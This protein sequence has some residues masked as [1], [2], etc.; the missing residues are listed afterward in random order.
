[1]TTPIDWDTLH[2]QEQEW[3]GL[4][5]VG[6]SAIVRKAMH[7][8]I[9][10][11]RMRLFKSNK[12]S[13]IKRYIYDD[14]RQIRTDA[15]DRGKAIEKLIYGTET[16]PGA[17][18]IRQKVLAAG[19]PCSITQPDDVSFDP[20]DA[21]LMFDNSN[22]YLPRILRVVP[23]A[24]SKDA[25]FE[26][27]HCYRDRAKEN[28]KMAM[29]QIRYGQYAINRMQ[30]TQEK[31]PKGIIVLLLRERGSVGYE[32]ITVEVLER[33]ATHSEELTTKEILTFAEE[34]HTLVTNRYDEIKTKVGLQK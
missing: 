26:F 23:D 22:P 27:K 29:E 25:I 34:L 11:S 10:V 12:D 20:I 4:R 19:L 17:D 14:K 21:P 7:P 5:E 33:P 1:M 2:K 30:G 6:I 15:M 28:L 18:E 16:A 32:N 31:T 13:F 8:H 9:S 3:D 24:L